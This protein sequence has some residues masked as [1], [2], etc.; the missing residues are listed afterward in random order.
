MGH[1]VSPLLLRI[2][3]IENWRSIWFAKKRD[4]PKFIQQD[5][6]IRKLIKKRFKQASISKI[7]NLK[8]KT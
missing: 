8:L 2:G 7:I 3:Y 6:E 4:Y 1:K 5:F